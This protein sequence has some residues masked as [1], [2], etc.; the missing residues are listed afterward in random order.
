MNR[1]QLI[2]AISDTTAIAKKDVTAILDAQD[3]LITQTLR[4]GAD[5]T[6]GKVGKL[7][8]KHNAARVGRNP[9]SGAEVQIAAKNSA[10]FKPSKDLINALA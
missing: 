7:M 10:K 1:S 9:Q 2:D 3:K 6:L 5:F 4:D 8:P